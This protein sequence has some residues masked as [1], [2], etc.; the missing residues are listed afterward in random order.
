MTH[1]EAIASLLKTCENLKD[2]IE[3]LQEENAFLTDTIVKN[4]L[5]QIKSERRTLLSENEKCKRDNDTI[6]KKANQIE[7]EYKT[8]MTEADNRLADARKKQSDVDF[9]IESEADKK[10]EDIKLEYE[11]YK[12]ANDKALKK[13]K[14]MVD[15]K[16][17]ETE[18]LYKEKNKKWI[19]FGTVGIIAII[20]NF[21]T[22][23][24]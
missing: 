23:I 14:K 10:I 15:K 19:V 22:Y 16:M 9:Y 17:K 6:L 13:H 21:L 1:D 12:K 7:A 24:L 11:E 5:G 8:K 2:A 18:M 4:N 20:I 3:Q